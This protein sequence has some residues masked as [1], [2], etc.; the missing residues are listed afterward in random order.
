VL[1]VVFAKADGS[2]CPSLSQ[3]PT[4]KGKR[5][6]IKLRP[7]ELPETLQQTRP[8]VQPPECKA[9]HQTRA[10]IEGTIS[11]AGRA[12][13]IRQTRYVGKAHTHLPHVATAAAINRERVADGFAGGKREKT[14]RS[15]FAR[16]LRSAL[17]AS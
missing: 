10:G 16:V 8:R 2:Q 3:C 4:A 14:R 6:S 1:N 13:G 5:R 15:A 11:Q 12:F 7:R 9:A 17:A